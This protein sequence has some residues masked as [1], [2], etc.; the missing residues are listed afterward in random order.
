M[1]EELKNACCF[2]QK[3]DHHYKHKSK[4][5]LYTPQQKTVVV[6]IGEKRTI[7]LHDNILIISEQDKTI[8]QKI[9]KTEVF[10][11]LRNL[12]DLDKPFFFLISLDI[13]RQVSREG[14]PL[15]IF[16]EP[17]LEMSFNQASQRNPLVNFGNEENY[18]QYLTGFQEE[19]LSHDISQIDSGDLKSNNWNWLGENDESF[20]SRL[21][22][23]VKILQMESEGKMILTRQWQKRIRS[24][25]D[26][27]SLFQIYSGLEPNCSA[28]HYFQWQNKFISLGC[29]P[30]NIF[31]INNNILSLDV[32]AG[33]RGIHSDKQKDIEWQWDLK[34]DPKEIA[35]HKMAFDRA[36]Q[37]ME[38]LCQFDDIVVKKKLTEKTL[39]Q[40]RH[41]YSYLEGKLKNNLCL[42][43]LLIDSYPSLISYP[44]KLINLADSMS[45]PS[46]FYGGML[47][48]NSVGGKISRCYLNL[49]AVL[50]YQD[51][52]YTQ[53][54]VGVIKNSI[55]NLE[56][57]ET[58]N[59]FKAINQAINYWEKSQ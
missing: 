39:S 21:H 15:M 40:V 51:Y 44:E 32:V 37:K 1:K 36:Y 34:N 13:Y 23:A 59:K 42:I 45:Q 17:E 7:T 49:R 30:E 14:L 4:Y 31:E 35:E 54:G 48:H 10:E 3:I 43:D 27:F 38:R 12:L 18:S 58:Y 20:L 16:I 26:Y 50:A 41:L 47:G 22:E 11:C 6:G 46:Y 5:L 53:T 55:P 24:N 9:D 52:L 56:L 57:L 25:H 2:L 29:S 8:Q 33:T 19:T 28:S